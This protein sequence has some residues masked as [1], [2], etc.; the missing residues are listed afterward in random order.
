MT[1]TIKLGPLR[2]LF[3]REYL[4][5]ICVAL[6]RGVPICCR[7]RRLYFF[8]FWGVGCCRNVIEL[9]SSNVGLGLVSLQLHNG[10]VSYLRLD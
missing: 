5:P 3:W 1:N 10:P 7:R 6:P 8:F 9:D 2:A 4:A